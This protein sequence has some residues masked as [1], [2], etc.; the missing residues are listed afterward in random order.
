MYEY[1]WFIFAAVEI[2]LQFTAALCAF[3]DHFYSI[4]G[5]DGK[6]DVEGHLEPCRYEY[7]GE[8]SSR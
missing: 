3:I 5:R 2:E 8:K 4:F 1:V 6:V 7:M